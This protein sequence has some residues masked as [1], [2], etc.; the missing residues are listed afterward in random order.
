MTDADIWLYDGKSGVAV[1]GDLVTFPAPFFETACP[2]AWRKALDEVWATPFKTAIPGHGEPMTRAQFDR[3]RGAFNRYMDCVDGP[4]ESG[5]C[6]ATWADGIADFTGTDERARK[7]ALGYAEYYVGM[8]REHGGQSADCLAQP[9]SPRLTGSPDPE[10]ALLSLAR[11][12]RL[13]DGPAVNRI[14]RLL[15]LRF[16]LPALLAWSAPQAQSDT[17]YDVYVTNEKSGDVTVISGV[18]FT[19]IGSFAVGKRPRGIHASPDGK[20]VYVALSGSPIQAP[21]RL[22]EKGVPIFDDKDDA[23]DADKAADG[24]GVIDVASRKLTGKIPVGSDP[25]EFSLSRDGTT[26][27]RL[28]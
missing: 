20:T 14:A 16:L 28:E 24:I 26:D 15:G 5:Q 18:D 27:L 8:L 25:E 22:D 1:I 19:V 21:P 7:M 23:D 12:R 17:P 9:R 4:S 3:Y 13:T 6:A 10:G 2:A 11:H